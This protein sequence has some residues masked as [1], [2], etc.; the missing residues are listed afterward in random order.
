MSPSSSKLRQT[1][2][3]LSGGGAKR[4]HAK[5]YCHQMNL[6]MAC[7][8]APCVKLDLVTS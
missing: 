4:I 6:S 2:N 8:G 3:G 1:I 7:L 5:T